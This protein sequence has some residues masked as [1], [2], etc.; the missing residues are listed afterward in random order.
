VIV[1]DS[2]DCNREI[3]FR[4][5]QSPIV[6]YFR[7][8]ERRARLRDWRNL[9]CGNS[10]F[11]C[12]IQAVDVTFPEEIEQPSVEL[13]NFDEGLMLTGSDEAFP[14]TLGIAAPMV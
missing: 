8:E 1:G 12:H 4:F 7:I 10:G 14:R 6:G 11:G 9:K 13:V 5:R 2:C 3:N